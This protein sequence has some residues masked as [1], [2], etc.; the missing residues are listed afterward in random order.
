MR[1]VGI[2][3]LIAGAALGG[4]W[5]WRRSTA[6]MYYRSP[7]SRIRPPHVSI[8]NYDAWVLARRKRWRLLKTALAAAVGTAIALLIFAMIDSGM[9][10]R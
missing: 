7:N 8:E 3:L 5:M 9:S 4:Y 6:T 10:R 2:V 1:I